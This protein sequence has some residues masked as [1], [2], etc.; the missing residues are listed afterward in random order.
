MPLKKGSSRENCISINYKELKASGRSHEVAQAASLNFCDKKWGGIPKKKDKKHEVSTATLDSLMDSI[1]KDLDGLYSI[2]SYLWSLKEVLNS[3]D[4]SEKY[5]KL[6][7]KINKD[8]E[9]INNID[10]S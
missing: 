4:F 1:D 8:L 2:R 5:N 7:E 6:R 3:D 9:K 10:V